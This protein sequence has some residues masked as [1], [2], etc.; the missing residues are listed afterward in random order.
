MKWSNVDLKHGF[1]LLEDTK[2]G[3]RREIPINKTLDATL[4]ALPRR[5]DVPYVFCDIKTGKPYTDI[6]DSFARAL[7]KVKISDFQ[8]HDLRHTFASQSVMAGVEIKAVQELLGHKTLS[9]CP[10]CSFP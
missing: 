2:N 8:F 3:D 7:G 9:I 4:R 5:L 1:I 6:R 10:P